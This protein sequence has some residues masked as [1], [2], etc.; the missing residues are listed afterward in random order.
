MRDK[1]KRDYIFEVYLNGKGSNFEDAATMARITDLNFLVN[2][3]KNNQPKT[4]TKTI[5][6][7]KRKKGDNFTNEQNVSEIYKLTKQDETRLESILLDIVMN[8]KNDA[9]CYDALSA[10]EQLDLKFTETIFDSKCD[11]NFNHKRAI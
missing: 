2:H 11:N 1:S 8:D 5:A 4:R 3:L 6:I 7:V 9:I 10:K